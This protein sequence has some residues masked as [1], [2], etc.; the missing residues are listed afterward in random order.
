M[1]QITTEQ[2][3]DNLVIHI[4]GAFNIHCFE[5]F[6][7]SY[8]ANMNGISTVEVDLRQTSDVD[9]SAMGMLMALWKVMRE[10]PQKVVVKNATGP[11]KELLE[12]GRL[13]DYMKIV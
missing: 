12:I 13:G 8:P 9:S 3:G 2:Q 5:E 4:S 6:H 10:D 7:Q 1:N 11:V